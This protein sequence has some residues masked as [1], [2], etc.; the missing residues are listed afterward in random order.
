MDK[1]DKIPGN[2]LF[3]HA[4]KQSEKIMVPACVTWKGATK[5]FF[6]NEDGLKVN[7][8]AYQKHLEKQ[9]FPEVGRLMNDTSWIFLQ[10]SAPSHRSNLVQNFLNER[11]V[12]KFIKHTE[13][14]PSSPDYNPLNYDFWN[15]IKEKVQEDRFGQPFKSEDE[16]KKKI[17][18][19]LSEVGQDLPEIRKALKQFPV[20]LHV[21]KKRVENASK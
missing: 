19:A 6:V 17:K 13:W 18:K 7:A 3:H 11:L 20:D 16:L 8:K 12:S 15:K 1:K 4:N 5:P 10:D 14:L 2:R 21:L 9:L